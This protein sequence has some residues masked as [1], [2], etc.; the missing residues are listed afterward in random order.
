MFPALSTLR[1]PY[2]RRCFL[3]RVF[4]VS[5]VCRSTTV[6]TPSW[7]SS[8]RECC[9]IRLQRCRRGRYLRSTWILRQGA[10]H[11]VEVRANI[12]DSPVKFD[13]YVERAVFQYHPVRP[14]LP[15]APAVADLVQTE[16]P[17]PYGR[18]FVRAL[19]PVT[20]GSCVFYAALF[21]TCKN[22]K[23]STRSVQWTEPS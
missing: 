1:L 19:P 14:T 18:Q 15:S 7:L 5:K 11:Q 23:S 9:G 17:C 20:G 4:R 16:V 21:V 6:P 12:P 3:A 13:R 2:C 22:T 10:W 8:F